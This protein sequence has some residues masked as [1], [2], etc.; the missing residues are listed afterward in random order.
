MSDDPRP[1]RHEFWPV[2]GRYFWDR[3]CPIC[4][5]AFT[6]DSPSRKYDRPECAEAMHAVYLERYADEHPDR[7]CGGGKR[8]R[9]YVCKGTPWTAAQWLDLPDG[10]RLGV[11]SDAEIA[12][13]IGK[14]RAGV[15]HARQRLGIARAVEPGWP[16]GSSLHGRWPSDDELRRQ[17]EEAGRRTA[18]NACGI[19]LT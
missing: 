5:R 2:P 6:T 11:Q 10:L 19:V 1:V 14:T 17:N 3:V 12:R 4:L 9:A 15:A 7:K 16:P 18:S 8:R 13:R